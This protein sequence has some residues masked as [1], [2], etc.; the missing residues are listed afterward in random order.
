MGLFDFFKRKS[1]CG[2]RFEG[3]PGTTRDSAVKILGAPNHSAGI[4]AEYQYLGDQFGQAGV[5]WELKGQGLLE[6]DD[7]RQYDQMRLKLRDGTERV[8]FFDIT[9]FFGK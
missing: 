8:I 1:S 5:D 9:E 2:I 7:G 3:G 6:G 4:D